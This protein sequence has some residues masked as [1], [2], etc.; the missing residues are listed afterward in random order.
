MTT[1]AALA[2]EQ[3]HH[4]A[5][6]QTAWTLENVRMGTWLFLASECLVF[7]SLLGTY[8]ALYGR[9]TSGPL[10]ADLLNIPVTGIAT[11]I[12]LASSFTMVM[13]IDA[14]RKG[15]TGALTSWL[16]LTIV[17]GLTFLGFQINEYREFIAEGLKLNT[18]VFGTT[19]YLLTGVHGS[20]VV[21]GSLWLTGVLVNS[22]RGK[23]SAKNAMAVEC[24]G[25]YW[26]FVDMAW[27]VIFPVVY[28]LE[29]A[30]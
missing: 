12:L 30:R 26:H 10:P 2:H 9:S 27:M 3:G 23:Y 7:G 4:D 18:N 21:I 13:A 19:F 22:L 14:I 28:L 17:L 16:A 15:K 25:M 24:A 20:H 8:L 1:H 29:F 5:H 11:F 6:D